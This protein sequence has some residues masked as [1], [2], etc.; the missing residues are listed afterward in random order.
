MN[1]QD[2]TTAHRITLTVAPQGFQLT[3]DANGWE[4]YSTRV[5]LHGFGRT[6][7]APWTQGTAHGDSIPEPGDVLDA[8]ASDAAAYLNARDAADFAADLGYEDDKQAAATYKAC[9]RIAERLQRFLGDEFE[10]VVW[11]L[12]RL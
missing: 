9:G 8:L 5:R 12:D 3:R 2:Y 10:T 6:M 4:H 1:A 7:I 11:E